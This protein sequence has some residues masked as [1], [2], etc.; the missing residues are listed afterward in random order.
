[1][2]PLANDFVQP[3]KKDSGEIFYPL[4]AMVCDN[5]WMV[6]LSYCHKREKIFSNEYPYY[7]SVSSS[8]LQ[9]AKDYVDKVIKDYRLDS[10]SKIIEVASND[11]YLLKNFKKI[12]AKVLGI[13]PCQNVAQFAISNNNVDTLVEFLTTHSALEIVKS[14]G[15][16]NLMIANNVLAHVPDI[17]DFIYGF[18]ILLKPEGLIT[19]EFPHILS[20]ISGNQF[21][22]IYHEHYSY[23]SLHA[24]QH[25]FNLAELRIFKVEFLKTH[26]G[27][28][29]V[30]VCH[31]QAS[32]IEDESYNHVINMEISNGIKDIL[33]Y[34][35]FQN[36]VQKT[37]RNLLSFLINAKESGKKV[38]AY[39]APAKGNTLL[40]YCGIGNDFL[41]FTV[42]LS[43]YKRKL[44]LPGSRLRILDPSE[45]YKIKPDYIL[46][47]PWNLKEEI[48]Q[49]NQSIKD[50]NGQFVIPI[51]ELMVI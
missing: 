40:N 6:Q 34:Q 16:A 5:C 39:G 24:V 1:M 28:L 42:D 20:L 51:P 37:K 26:G 47:L 27:S 9:H 17:N 14:Y 50:W 32:Y 29:R 30:Y 41:D 7:S 49:Q 25:A 48:I 15:Q 11:G 31:Q 13:E 44:L 45:I 4:K 21:D 46:I 33:M 2:S 38:I 22:T 35:N 12:N 36:K 10:S 8:W 43:P 18:K 3:D 19:F 23:L